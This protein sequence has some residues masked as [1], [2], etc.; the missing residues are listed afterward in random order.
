[1]AVILGSVTLDS[2]LLLRGAFETPSITLDQKRLLS[3]SLY[4]GVKPLLGRTLIL[5]TDGP[6]N[7]KYG[8]FTR[9]QLIQIAALR[10][11]GSPILLTHN[12]ESF[13]VMI[14][15]T[16][17]EVEPIVE[18]TTKNSTDLYAGSITLIEV[19]M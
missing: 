17:I 6:N 13:N 10:D 5:T 14:A 16:G 18:S 2:R 4:I 19:L 9:T 7:I 3:G 1:M 15:D 12:T 11:A 8:L